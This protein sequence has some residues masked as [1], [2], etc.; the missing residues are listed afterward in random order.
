MEPA[1]AGRGPGARC[2][3][4]EHGRRPLASLFRRLRASALILALSGCSVLQPHR[5]AFDEVEALYRSESARSAAP[6]PAGEAVAACAPAEG[7]TPFPLTLQAMRDFRVRYDRP[8]TELAQLTVLEGMIYLQSG[9]PGMAALLREDVRAAGA[10]LSSSGRTARDRLFADSFASLIEGWTAI[11][12]SQDQSYQA[13]SEARRVEAAAN[14]IAAILARAAAEGLADPAADEA[15]LYL[16]ATA[17]QFRMWAYAT[18]DNARL[19][20]VGCDPA[21]RRDAVDAARRLIGRFLSD[22]ERQAAA[23]AGPD[24]APSRIRYL[25][26]YGYLASEEAGRCPVP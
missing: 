14:A 20:D 24:G 6:P 9:Q 13:P 4:G 7:G 23:A 25:W 22:T 5:A 16:A 3:G 2:A 15:A 18:L 8:R 11:C 12:G 26:W 19:A 21:A 10:S 17:A 1:G